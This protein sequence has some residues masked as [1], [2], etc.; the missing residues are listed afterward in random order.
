MLVALWLVL[1]LPTV[2]ETAFRLSFELALE[3]DLV[4][5]PTQ[6]GLLYIPGAIAILALVGWLGARYAVYGMRFAMLVRATY[7]A[8]GSTRTLASGIAAWT[9]F[10]LGVLYFLILQTIS[11]AL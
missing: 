1:L 11:F 5:S 9:V 6:L 2:V 8:V 3:L 7:L 4:L 10:D